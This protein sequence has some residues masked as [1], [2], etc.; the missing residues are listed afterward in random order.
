MTID[1]NNKLWVITK[2]TFGGND[3]KLFRINTSSLAIEEEIELNIN[4]DEDLAITP[5]KK[6]LIYSNGQS[7]YKISITDT[8]AP[9]DTWIEATDVQKLYALDVNPNNG[10]VYIG[11]ALDYVSP[12]KVYVYNAD[13]TFKESFEAGISPT[14]FIFK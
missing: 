9:G 2:G 7:I 10:E 5:D 1:S 13:G 4:P 12:G 8:K 11:D 14:Q 3:G 6:N